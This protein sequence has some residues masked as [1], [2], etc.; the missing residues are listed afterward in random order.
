[1]IA[2]PLDIDQINADVTMQDGELPITPQQMAKIVEHV[3][4]CL[5]QR[6]RDQQHTQAVT[7]IRGSML[8]APYVDSGHDR[9]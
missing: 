4:R 5:E 1:V 9:G 3:L 7:T 8:P 6:Q 2:V